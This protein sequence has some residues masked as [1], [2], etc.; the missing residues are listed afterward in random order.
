MKRG[1]ETVVVDFKFGRANRA[2]SDQVKQYMLLLR[3]M[4]YSKVRGYLWYVANET[5]E[6][7]TL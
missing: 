6:E 5:I 4:G 2:Y 1:D 3:D 7:I